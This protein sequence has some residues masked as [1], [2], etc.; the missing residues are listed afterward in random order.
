MSVG[1]RV[2]GW[3]W[4]PILQHPSSLP[5]AQEDS[6]QSFKGPL[7]GLEKGLSGK[8]SQEVEIICTLLSSGCS[9]PSSPH[10]NLEQGKVVENLPGKAIY[11]NGTQW[12]R[13][14]GPLMDCQ[15][16]FVFYRAQELELDLWS[17]TQENLVVWICVAHI[18]S[19]ESW[20][21][22]NNHCSIREK[23]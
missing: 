19:S 18:A 9:S 3:G 20:L 16:P 15:L 4:S 14:G 5:S 22:V 7:G 10:R 1:R 6:F 2:G 17:I 23:D 12:K 13:V 8:V 11:L 21:D